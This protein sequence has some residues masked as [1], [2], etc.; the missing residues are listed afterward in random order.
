MHDFRK[1]RVWQEGIELADE[2]YQLTRNFP[3]EERFNL[4]SQLNRAATSIPSNVAEGAGRLHNGEF[5]QFLGF[6]SGSCSEVYTHLVLAQRRHYLT[7][8]QFTALETRLNGIHR[9]IATL[10][11]SLRAN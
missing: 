9:M 2:L 3:T 10:I 11:K 5:I 4:T 6:A 1:L 8:E 7:S